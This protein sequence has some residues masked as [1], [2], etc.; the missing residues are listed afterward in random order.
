MPC[1]PEYTNRILLHT[2]ED[3][4]TKLNQT[5]TWLN[6]LRRR[7]PERRDEVIKKMNVVDGMIVK[8]VTESGVLVNKIARGCQDCTRQT[9]Y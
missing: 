1:L 3:K 9:Q 5:K 6:T 4:L 8:T 2:K 7:E